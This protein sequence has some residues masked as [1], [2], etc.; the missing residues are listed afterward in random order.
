M[1]QHWLPSRTLAAIAQLKLDRKSGRFS[2][3]LE[4]FPLSKN[5]P[6]PFSI[7]RQYI[8]LLNPSINNNLFN[9][10]KQRK[11]HVEAM[12]S[13]HLPS[14]YNRGSWGFCSH[15]NHTLID[16]DS[17]NNSLGFIRSIINKI[18]I[19]AFGVFLTKRWRIMWGTIYLIWS[20]VSVRPS[21]CLFCC[22][23][24]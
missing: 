19:C 9:N 21:G 23:V 10:E 1:G 20:S 24:V 5:T 18:S 13:M 15:L 6:T 8:L 3:V 14:L 11:R 7:P 16:Q 2:F 22:H 17:E 4:N 12:R